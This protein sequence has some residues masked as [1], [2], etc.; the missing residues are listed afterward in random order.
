MTLD[1]DLKRRCANLLG[2]KIAQEVYRI[3]DGDIASLMMSWSAI[4]EFKVAVRKPLPWE[5]L[6]DK[7]QRYWLDNT[8][9]ISAAII[10]ALPELAREAGY[11][12]RKE[13]QMMLNTLSR[14]GVIMKGMI[15]KEARE[16]IKVG[17]LGATDTNMT[18]DEAVD[19]IVEQL[20]RF[21][22]CQLSDDQTLPQVDKRFV[23]PK[24]E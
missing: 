12:S 10:K 18:I 13:V 23:K 24:P 1:Y 5:E 3:T 4:D 8:S 6:S 9:G 20:E 21:N 14:T 11:L 22:C 15:S 17:V 16:Q 7:K 19:Y 2:E